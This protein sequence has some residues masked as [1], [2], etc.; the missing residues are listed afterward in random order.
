MKI[1]DGEKLILLM[2]TE[3]YQKLNI[4]GEI[5]PEFLQSALFTDNLWGIPW[6][7][8][9]IPFD[10][11]ETPPVVKEVVDILDMWMFIERSFEELTADEKVKVETEADPFGKDPK[12]RGFDGNN[13]SKHV[14]AALFLIKDLGRFTEFRDRDLN[15]HMS[16]IERHQRM[17]SVFLPVRAQLDG[18]LMTADELIRVLNEKVYPESR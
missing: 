17:L 12:F 15:A 5:D 14:S 7:F 8:N 4:D 11:T 18:R 13:E 3:I 9:G 1:T 6:R 16:T 2:L 10:K